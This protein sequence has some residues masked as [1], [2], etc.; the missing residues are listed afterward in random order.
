MFCR[1]PQASAASF[2]TLRSVSTLIAPPSLEGNKKHSMLGCLPAFRT[3]HL[4]ADRHPEF[5]NISY[6]GIFNPR[7]NIVYRIATDS[8]PSEIIHTVETAVIGY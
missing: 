2:K 5:K 8:I 4:S 1:T 6:L 3:Y 7:L